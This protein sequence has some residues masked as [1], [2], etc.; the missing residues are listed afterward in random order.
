MSE[1]A[2]IYFG[3]VRHRRWQP[4]THSFAYR[5]FFVGLDLGALDRA[6]AGRWLWSVSRPALAWFRRSD[7]FG[8]ADIPL[9]ECVRDLV[10]TET[11]ER[12]AGRVLL[13][14]HL[15]YFGYVINPISLYYCFD[16]NDA[17][18][19]VVAEVENTPWREKHCY[20]IP[21]QNSDER[22]HRHENPKTFH[23]SP[24]M[25]MNLRYRWALT[26]PGQ[27]IAE[28]SA[29]KISIHLE[30]LAQNSEGEKECLFDATLSLR[31]CDATGKRLAHTL[32]WHPLMTAKVALA[33]YW[34]AICLWWKGATFFT[35]PKKVPVNS[36]D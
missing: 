16:A 21:I 33:I 34:Q 22:V 35:H 18:Q 25:P 31:R 2:C 19:A 14:T 26:S 9:D 17:L 3:N 15:R 12:P 1:S 20:V 23:V 8:A 13:L 11:G 28:G 5:V 24:F 7:H 32:F 30:T 27:P 36:T 6:F 4:F 29:N 10:E